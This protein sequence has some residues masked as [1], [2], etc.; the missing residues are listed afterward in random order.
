MKLVSMFDDHNVDH[1][2]CG[3]KHC[4]ETYKIRDTNVIISGA[5]SAWK[6]I[7]FDD[8]HF[9]RFDVYGNYVDKEKIYFDD[10]EMV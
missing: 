8:Y 7:I 5:A 3:H 10:V 2:L 1:F 6:D 4:G 9:Y